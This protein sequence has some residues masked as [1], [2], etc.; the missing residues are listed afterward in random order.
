VV[1]AP[2]ESA[3]VNFRNMDALRTALMGALL[4]TFLS[5]LPFVNCVAAGYFAVL[6]YRRRT[7]QTV[8]IISGVRIGWLTGLMA[9]PMLAAVMALELHSP[10][11]LEMMKTTQKD[12][13]QQ[14]LSI[15]QNGP[16]LTLLLAMS[17]VF[18]TF[19]S[20][21]G[22]LLGAVLTGRPNPRPPGGNT[23]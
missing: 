4:A 5:F 17:L 13:L 8:N 23:V 16:Q 21:T 6:F 14:I 22:G 12:N 11:F 3:P 15:I 2:V 20:M 19:L 7:R 18:I 9:F 10:S 1:P